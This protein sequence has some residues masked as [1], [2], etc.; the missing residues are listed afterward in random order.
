MFGPSAQALGESP[1]SAIPLTSMVQGVGYGVKHTS[2]SA[3]DGQPAIR[4]YVRTKLTEAEVPQ[5]DLVPKL[6]NGVPTDVVATGDIRKYAACGDSVGHFN[7]TAGTLGCIATLVGNIQDRY[8]LSNNHVL[9]DENRAAIG[10]AIYAPGPYDGG[11]PINTIA[12]LSDF[13]AIDFAGHPNYVDAAI[14]KLI[15]PLSVPPLIP[16][17]GRVAN[18]PASVVLYQSVRKKGRTTRHT[19]GIVTDLSASIRVGYDSG[20]AMFEDQIGITGAGGDF[21]AGGDSGSLIVDA[22]TLRPIGLLFAGGGGLTFA[23]PIDKVLARFDAT[24]W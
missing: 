16:N 5:S 21:S 2:G 20:V 8:I 7:I 14:A 13:Q 3:V 18:P 10:D 24:I 6:I 4:V 23:N 15:D 12:D 22:I 19:V 17:I 11:L 1:L 9:A